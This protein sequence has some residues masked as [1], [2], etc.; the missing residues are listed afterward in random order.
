MIALSN[1]PEMWEIRFLIQAVLPQSAHCLCTHWLCVV[2]WPWPAAKH[3]HSSSLIHLSQWGRGENRKSK[4]KETH[5]SRQR[6]DLISR[7]KEQKPSDAKAII[8]HLPSADWCPAIFWATSALE[9][10]A[11]PPPSF[12]YGVLLL[13]M[14]LYGT[15]YHSGQFGSAVPAVSPPSFLPIPSLLTAG[16]QE[17]RVGRWES[18]DAVQA[19]P[20]NNQNISVLWTFFQPQIQNTAPYG[21]LRR[22]LTLFRADLLQCDLVLNCTIPGVSKASLKPY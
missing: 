12:S 21:L 1:P 22:K 2:G 6:Q 5:G 19:L 9:A 16:W 4:R 11:A 8:H 18:L 7:K 20:S 17:G 3:P 10:K 13:S 14:M 15:E